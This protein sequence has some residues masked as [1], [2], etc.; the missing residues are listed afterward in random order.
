MD[1]NG[2]NIMG[3]PMGTPAFVSSYLQ[4]KDLKHLLLLWFINDVASA[5]FPRE[6]ELMLKGAAVSR[7]SHILRSV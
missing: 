4:G 2:V 7:L 6:A 1:E 5:G 3:T